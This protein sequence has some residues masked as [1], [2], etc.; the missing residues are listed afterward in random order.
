MGEKINISHDYGIFVKAGKFEP[1][2][3]YACIPNY[4][5]LAYA[6]SFCLD[7]GASDIKLI[8]VSGLNLDKTQHKVMQELINILLNKEISITSLTPTSFALKEQ[9]IFAI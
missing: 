7:A 8:G 1:R 9:S 6:I 3:S 5:T 2:G 4:L